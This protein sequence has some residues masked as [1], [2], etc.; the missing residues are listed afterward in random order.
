[1]HPFQSP[2][3]QLLLHRRQPLH[4]FAFPTT[5]T[6]DPFISI[7]PLLCPAINPCLYDQ[8]PPLLFPDHLQRGQY[9]SYT[10]TKNHYFMKKRRHTE[11]NMANL[12]YTL[13]TNI[14][15]THRRRSS[16]SSSTRSSFLVLVV[17]VLVLCVG[18]VFPTPVFHVPLTL[19]RPWDLLLQLSLQQLLLLVVQLLLLQYLLRLRL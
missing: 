18:G 4:N 17:F 5:A 9:S 11:R 8:S 13:E 3:L 1:M 15:T 12:R 6:M 10:M 2:C 16:S 14:T 7:W 19:L